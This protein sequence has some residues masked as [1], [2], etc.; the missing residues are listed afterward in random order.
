M[1]GKE[2]CGTLYYR[3]RKFFTDDDL[4]KTK[5]F[6]AGFVTGE[7]EKVH[8][9]ACQAAMFRP[10]ADRLDWMAG[11]CGRVCLEYDL[12]LSTLDTARGRELWIYRASDSFALDRLHQLGEMVRSDEVNT[13][14]WHAIRGLLCGVPASELDVEFHKR[15]HAPEA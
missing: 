3:A 1:S 2:T 6:S 5:L 15:T 9:G 10:S 11:I 13:P 7:A 8:L 4:E 12:G 14:R